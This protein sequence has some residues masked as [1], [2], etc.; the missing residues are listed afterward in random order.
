MQE[1][2][3]H[4]FVMTQ[5]E[6]IPHNITSIKDRTGQDRTGQDRTGQDT[7]AFASLTGLDWTGPDRKKKKKKKQVT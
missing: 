5:Q 3:S 6:I 7:P 2:L 1:R 4:D